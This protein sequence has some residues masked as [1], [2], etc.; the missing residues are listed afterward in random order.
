VP[1]HFRAGEPHA[2]RRTRPNPTPTHVN[3]RVCA[4]SILLDARKSEDGPDYATIPCT[5]CSAL[6]PIRRSDAAY[7]RDEQL[8]EGVAGPPGGRDLLGRWRRRR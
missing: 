2:E 8:G 4:T 7:A 3:C 1:L 5:A 6:V